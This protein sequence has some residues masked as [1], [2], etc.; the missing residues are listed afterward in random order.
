EGRVKLCFQPAEEPIKGAVEKIEKGVLENPHVD[1]VFGTHTSIPMK[2]GA[3]RLLEGPILASSDIF[4]VTIH[5][6]GSHG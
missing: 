3:V 1:A 2:A 5:G 6:E 4:K